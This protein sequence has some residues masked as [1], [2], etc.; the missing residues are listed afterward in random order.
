LRIG[1]GIS[2]ERPLGPLR[3]DQ[4]PLTPTISCLNI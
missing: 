2:V 3:D 4:S 1:P